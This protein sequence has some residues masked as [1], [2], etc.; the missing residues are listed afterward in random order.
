MKSWIRSTSIFVLASALLIGCQTKEA[1]NSKPVAETKPVVETKKE[2]TAIELLGKIQENKKAFTYQENMKGE[3]Q[4]AGMQISF[5][6]S[7]KVEETSNPEARHSIGTSKALGQEVK[8]ESYEKDGWIYEYD[9]EMKIWTKAKVDSKVSDGADPL[10]NMKS[11]IELLKFIKDGVSSTHEGSTY[12]II[13][14]SSKAKNNSLIKKELEK[15]I[16]EDTDDPEMS[17]MFKGVQFK[18]FTMT[19]V[20]NDQT[21]DPISTE[22]TFEIANDDKANP[23]SIK[24]TFKQEQYASFNGTITVPQDVLKKAKQL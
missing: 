7:S 21:F 2:L 19:L 13:I 1:T 22:G 11:P 3:L 6:E 15:A 20:V 12:K 24:V 18:K 9:G 16:V 14:D 23:A 5:E 17:A 8:K 4:F 10:S